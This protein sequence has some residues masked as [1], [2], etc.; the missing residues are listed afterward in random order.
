MPIS[1][2]ESGTSCASL[3]VNG[4]VFGAAATGGAPPIWILLFVDKLMPLPK[5][6]GCAF[7]K[8]N[9]LAAKLRQIIKNDGIL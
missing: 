1:S 6:Y 9:A 7:S 4:N 8:S 5:R 2:G 3:R